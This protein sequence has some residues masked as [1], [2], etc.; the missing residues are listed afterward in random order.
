MCIALVVLACLL[1][2]FPV[3]VVPKEGK[4]I[5]SDEPTLSILQYPKAVTMASGGFA[6]LSM[7]VFNGGEVSLNIT[8]AV[9]QDRS[10]HEAV[11]VLPLPQSVVEAWSNTTIHLVLRG[12][13][14]YDSIAAPD[15]FGEVITAI[16]V[17]AL[18]TDDT[19]R[20][21][22]VTIETH[23]TYLLL[24]ELSGYL[25]VVGLFSLVVYIALIRIKDRA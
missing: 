22:S 5:G 21:S 9:E 8:L 15:L 11:S 3:S 25:L 19:I 17:T 13:V 10:P 20:S 4:A 7:I 6:D 24:P 16:F 18:T 12:I 14:W 2:Q 1:G 23:I